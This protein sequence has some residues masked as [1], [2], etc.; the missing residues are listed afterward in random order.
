MYMN[1][2]FNSQKKIG[3]IIL[4]AA[5]VMAGF[6][7]FYDSDSFKKSLADIKKEKEAALQ[8]DKFSLEQESKDLSVID[9]IL[10]NLFKNNNDN[11]LTNKITADISQKILSLNQNGDLEEGKIM[12]PDESLLTAEIINNHKNDFFQSEENVNFQN[13]LTINDDLPKT[14]LEYF[15][16]L[17]IIIRDNNITEEHLDDL[18]NE[19][20]ETENVE[21][22]KQPIRGMNNAIL[23]LKKVR[24]PNSWLSLHVDFTNLLITKKI[25]YQSFYN[26]KNDPLKAAI[27]SQ[28]ID[29]LNNSLNQ[30]YVAVGEKLEQDGAFTF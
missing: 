24:V 30:W 13:F 21:Y 26:Q 3:L 1:L 8:V 18:L 20:L 27:A 11:N 2:I 29:D 23:Q 12:V 10:D 19:F 14:T 16:N 25:F 9:G 7:V 4:G 6:L 28:L 15:Q 5:L 17:L 22:L